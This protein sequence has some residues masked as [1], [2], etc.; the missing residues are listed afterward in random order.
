[1]SDS[2]N[3]QILVSGAASDTGSNEAVAVPELQVTVLMSAN[4]AL[5][6]SRP[7]TRKS[8]LPSQLDEAV[9]VIV[10]PLTL[11]P[12]AVTAV[13]SFPT[14]SSAG[15]VTRYTSAHLLP[16]E[17]LLADGLAEALVP[18]DAAGPFPEALGAAEALAVALG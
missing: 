10:T 14:E 1:M 15:D 13:H 16:S 3:P 17:E 5:S 8:T 11:V 6:W 4:S 2:S 12:L 9:K 18:V 7:D